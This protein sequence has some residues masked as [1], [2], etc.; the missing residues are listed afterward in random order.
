MPNHANQRSKI[1]IYPRFQLNFLAH[2]VGGA[3]ITLGIFFAGNR[4]FFW[5]FMQ[6]GRELGLP[7]GHVFYQFLNA[8]RFALDLVFVI[9]GLAAL[10]TLFFYG[11]YL[12]HRVVGPMV[13]LQHHLKELEENGQAAP[14]QFRE[15][16]YFQ[17]V[18][19]S[20]N[21]CIGS[22]TNRKKHSA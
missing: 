7:D 14:L 22:M 4:Y 21:S 15:D 8:Q 5:K 6:K 19:E 11:L 13:R 20:V 2:M 9:S 18:A 16:D 10:A 1:L 17:E 12:S 3:L